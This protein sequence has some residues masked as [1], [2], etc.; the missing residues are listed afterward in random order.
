MQIQPRKDV[1]DY[2][3]YTAPTHK[4]EVDRAD[5]EYICLPCMEDLDHEP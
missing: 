3:D 2:A 1:I 4:H 5:Q